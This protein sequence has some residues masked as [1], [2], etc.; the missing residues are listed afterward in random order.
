MKPNGASVLLG[1]MLL[2]MSSCKPDKPIGPTGRSA[3]VD[4]RQM[5][6]GVY[7]V[8]DT[9]GN[10]RYEMEISLYQDAN[11]YDSLL[12][13]GWGGAFDVYVQRNQGNTSNYLNFIGSFGIVDH[14]GHRW[15]LYSEYDSAFQYNSLINDT[16]R[17]SYLKDNIA[18]Y[19]TN[20]VPYFRQ[21]YRE[22][23]VKR[24]WE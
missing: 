8:Y 1:V 12:I 6:L 10:W 7:D 5:F 18:F 2:F 4:G 22:F 15:A 13:E 14:I 20:G 11:P 9:L 23:A 16:L 17:L 3:P 19:V 24:D 21:S